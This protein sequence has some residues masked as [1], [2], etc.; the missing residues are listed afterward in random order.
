[1]FGKFLL[2]GLLRNAASDGSGEG[3][4]GGG[5]EN[6]VPDAKAIQ[7]MIDNSLNGYAK[8]Q[9]KELDA[10]LKT[11]S[12]TLGTR[13]DEAFARMTGS[14]SSGNGDNGGGTGDGDGHGSDNGNGNG[15]NGIKLDPATKAR[16]DK[17]ERDT[18]RANDQYESERKAREAAEAKAAE[19]NRVTAIR[20]EL[21]KY[22]ILPENV[23]DVFAIFD[24]KVKTDED[25][26]Y[27]VGDTTMEAYVRQTLE[28][29]PGVL[30]PENRSGSGSAPGK[31]GKG[32][33]VALEDI[34]AG[35]SKD[36]LSAARA[37]IVKHLQNA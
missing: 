28:R 9:G 15:S 1:M 26:Q 7:T 18:K 25:G 34:K 13:L 36:V 16:L 3:S 14:G 5:T 17:L 19:T 11:F 23:E 31:G 8:R 4:N 6:P 10:K 30:R 33:K 2:F 35:A 29:M 20:T 21:Q 37:E 22:Q 24:G 27:I 12:D 32:G